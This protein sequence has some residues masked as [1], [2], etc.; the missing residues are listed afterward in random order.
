MF[1]RNPTDE[2]LFGVKPW[3]SINVP[4]AHADRIN[5]FI[6]AWF[7]ELGEAFYSS[8]EDFDPRI[9]FRALKEIIR[10]YYDGDV[11]A[12]T[13]VDMKLKYIELGITDRIPLIT[14]NGEDCQWFQDSYETSKEEREEQ[15]TS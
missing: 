8:L 9:C 13:I 11:D 12:M 3:S 6:E 1:L 5:D 14:D 15:S 10:R 4:D 7:E 2:I